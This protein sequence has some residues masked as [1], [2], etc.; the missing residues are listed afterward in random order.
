LKKKKKVAAVHTKQKKHDKPKS[1]FSKK[2][3]KPDLKASLFISFGLGFDDFALCA[4]VMF[5]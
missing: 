3:K 5:G 2:K 1:L 4:F